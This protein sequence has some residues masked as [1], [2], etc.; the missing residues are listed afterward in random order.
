MFIAPPF[1]NITFKS[2]S[3]VFV[4]NMDLL[5]TLDKVSICE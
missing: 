4:N 2:P 1:K 5:V 3:G